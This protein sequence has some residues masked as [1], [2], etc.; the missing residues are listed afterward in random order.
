[1]H[2]GNFACICAGVHTYCWTVCVSLRSGLCFVLGVFISVFC[3]GL[4]AVGV[5]FGLE[6]WCFD[7]FGVF[8]FGVCCFVLRLLRGCYDVVVIWVVLGCTLF[9]FVVFMAC[10]FCGFVNFGAFVRYCGLGCGC[11][12]L[13][14]GW[15]LFVCLG[16]LCV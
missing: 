1:M 6:F 12:C 4:T 14:F 7:E 10:L 5:G 16:V 3:L 11:L 8:G 15:C 9:G 13:R 2:V